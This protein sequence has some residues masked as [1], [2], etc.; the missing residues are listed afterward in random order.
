MKMLVLSLFT[1]FCFADELPIQNDFVNFNNIKTILKKDGL[2][3]IVEKK[4]VEKQKA[5]K[6]KEDKLRSMYNTPNDED[7]WSIMMQYWL[8]KNA[9]ILKWDFNR[10]DY[11]MIPAFEAFLKE[12]GEYG[13]KFKLLFFNSSNITHFAFPM[14]K[15]SYLFVISVPFIKTMDLSKTQISALLYEDLIRVKQGHFESMISA[16]TLSK[17]RNTN[18]FQKL[19][20]KKEISDLLQEIDQI[21]YSKGFNFQQQ[22]QVTKYVNTVLLN[23]K[24]L[25]QNYYT[26]INKIDELTKGNLLF[27]NY[28]KIYPSPE[29][30]K[31]WIDPSKK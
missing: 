20:P 25:W 12:V 5:D 1:I 22:Y 27:K 28:A 24:K 23:N 10:P 26:L 9:S 2:E 16:T 31:S 17:L 13:V 15:D 19:V 4:K 11:G 3:K 6:Q 8:V 14:G 7:F 30:Q 29:L 18:F 21:V